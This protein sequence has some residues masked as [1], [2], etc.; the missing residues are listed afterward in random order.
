MNS[1]GIRR[2]I[3]VVTTLLLMGM[4]DHVAAKKSRHE[5]FLPNTD[6]ELNVYR[7]FGE[8]PG[9]TIMIIGG[10]QG[11]EPGGY[12]TADLYADIALKKGNLI[13]VPRANFYSILLNRREGLTGDMNRK[14]GSYEKGERRNSLEQ[15]I[16]TILKHMIA[17]S[18]CLINLHEGSGYYSPEWISDIENP[19]RYGQS[20]IYDTDMYEIPGMEKV[21]R[22]GDFAKKMVI[23]VNPQI[24]NKR[25]KFKTNNHNTSST[26][27]LHKE[28]RRSATYYALTKAHIPAF[29]IE[30]SK[31]IKSIETKVRLQ[32]MVVNAFMEEMGIVLDSPGVNIYQPKLDYLLIKVNTGPAF[33]MPSGSELEID[34]G[35]EIMV[36]DIVANYERGLVADILGLGTK[37]DTNRPFRISGPTRVV[38][39]KD[40]EQCGWVDIKT[41]E[42]AVALKKKKRVFISEDQLKVEQLIIN[43]DNERIII[44]AG[45]TLTVKRGARLILRG[46]RTNIARLDNDVIV[47]FKGFAP[48]KAINDGNDLNYPIYT[49]QDLWRRYSINKKGTVYP[50]VA[51]YKDRKVG[52]FW[53]ELN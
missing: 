8:E 50:V 11:D 53:I 26:N 19:K 23:K 43:I 10:I 5:I 12:L 20:I 29:G 44:D 28:Q 45:E 9:R 41:E 15:E 1:S 33:A 49:E 48:P 6:H 7:V 40:A 37:N 13:V 42:T 16:V 34:A 3:V 36:T 47:N 35:D 30:T 25:Y 17:E 2:L 22:L 52:K 24:K 38:V 39:R 32:K 31:S 18:D 4:A 51:L 21:I 14:F 46:V 27:S